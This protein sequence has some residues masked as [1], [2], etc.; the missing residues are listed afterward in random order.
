MDKNKKIYKNN[1]MEITLPIL[2]D[3]ITADMKKYSE[4]VIDSILNDDEIFIYY[5]FEDVNELYVDFYLTISVS[6]KK[7]D[8]DVRVYV[9]NKNSELVYTESYT[10]AL[11]PEEEDRFY[12][13]ALCQ[14]TQNYEHLSKYKKNKYR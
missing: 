5:T 7:R 9:C 1:T 12:W 10:P 14:I 3:S 6:G 4:R 13:E 11:T 2:T 8:F